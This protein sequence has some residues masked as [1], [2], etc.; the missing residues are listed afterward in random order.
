MRYCQEY[1]NGAVWRDIF[2]SIVLDELEVRKYFFNNFEFSALQDLTGLGKANQVLSPYLESLSLLGINNQGQ[3]SFNALVWSRD[4]PET[5]LA[6]YHV[7][8]NL[9]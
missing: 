8:K 4:N 5:I 7:V 1:Q 3:S 6:G 2:Q 9:T